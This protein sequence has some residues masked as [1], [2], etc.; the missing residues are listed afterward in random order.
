M[1]IRKL[2]AHIIRLPLKRPFKHASATR[3]DSDNVL[4]RCELADG[5]AGW[6]EGVPRSYVT[7]E[8]PDGCLAQ[9]A[10][11]PITEQLSRDCNS[12]PDVIHLCEQFKPAIDCDDPRRCYGN[13][14]RCA[15]EL[16]ILDVFGRLFG[17]SVSQ[18]VKH[19][20]P[21]QSILKQRAS[22]Q[23]SAA[24]DSGSRGLVRK[25]LVLRSYGF[26]QCKV[27]VGAVGDDDVAR[28]RTIRR[29]IGPRMDLRLDANEAW[30]ASDVRAK[31]EP[32]MKFSIGC[33][34]QPLPHEEVG[35]LAELRKQL[36]VPIMLDESL[37]SLA[38]A[39]AAIDG[40]TC[41][42]FNIRLS[43]CGGFLNSLRL[44]ATA[45][46]AGLGYQLGCHPGESGILSAAG[47]HWAC[48]M[49]GIRYLEGSY[50]RHLLRKLPTNE[51]I[52]FRYGGR[53]PSL[54]GRGLGVTINDS[55]LEQMTL[56]KQEYVLE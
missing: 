9:L 53:A 25:S 39:Q 50:D 5:S 16:S 55:V 51:D 35:R 52:T 18:L 56:A 38:D 43:K 33:V 54:T 1:R 45:T 49:Q 7:G 29:W 20:S 48:N 11:T 32:L 40:H 27:K 21:A 31:I 8:T 23:Y 34:E 36:C 15:V 17:E 44:A 26:R 4:I 2:T 28:L 12:W 37:T 24:I 22:V 3:N 30:S 42:L 13:A 19:F 10:A 47:R 6:G 14:L 46:E 41:D